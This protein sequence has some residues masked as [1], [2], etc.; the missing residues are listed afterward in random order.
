MFSR[1]LLLGYNYQFWTIRL[2]FA[3]CFALCSPLT[4]NHSC[5]YFVWQ[6]LY[7]KKLIAILFEVIFIQLTF[8][9]YVI[10]G[11]WSWNFFCHEIYI[12]VVNTWGIICALFSSDETS[13]QQ[14]F[15]F[16]AAHWNQV[17]SIEPCIQCW[18]P[19][20]LQ[21]NKHTHD[22]HLVALHWLRVV[23]LYFSLMHLRL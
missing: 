13:T 2:N 11:S 15:Q 7:V 17:H 22:I 20:P 10:L 8:W 23:V 6:A 5:C 9:F 14:F 21:I 1:F 16:C 18:P 12:I 3:T 4:H 19:I